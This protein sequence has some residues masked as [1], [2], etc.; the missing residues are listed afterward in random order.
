M[1]V[2]GAETIAAA[3]MVIGGGLKAV[4]GYQQQ[5]A[6]AAESEANARNLERQS[7]LERDATSH[8]RARHVDRAKRLQA[9]QVSSASASGFNVDGSTLDFIQSTAVEQDLDLQALTYSGGIK[10]DNLTVQSKQARFNAKSQRGGAIYAGIAP[11]IETAT[12][13]G[14]GFSRGGAFG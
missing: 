9:K 6:L 1:C 4:S 12:K 2:P 8:E 3:A 13:L 10:A 5:R 7:L 14:T 11:I